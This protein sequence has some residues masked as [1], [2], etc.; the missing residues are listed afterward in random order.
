LK[1]REMRQGNGLRVARIP[2]DVY[3]Q[4]SAKERIDIINEALR[5]RIFIILGGAFDQQKAKKQFS[6]KFSKSVS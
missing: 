6:K 1:E 4:M 2:K 3:G 5:A